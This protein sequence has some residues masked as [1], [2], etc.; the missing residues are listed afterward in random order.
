MARGN[1][2]VQR[3]EVR[4]T[5]TVVFCD[6]ADS[7]G[8]GERM[9]PESLRHLMRR[10]Y[11][12]MRRVVEV[13]GG[14]CP[15]F[16]GDAVMAVFGA[17]ALHEDDA[18]RAVR[19]AVGMASALETLNPEL[20]SRWGVRLE[21]KTGVNTGQV[22][23]GALSEGRSFVLGDPVNVAARLQGAAAAG[24]I[25]IGEE[26]HRLVRAFVRTEPVEPL[27]LKGKAQ[28]VRAYTVVGFVESPSGVR[29]GVETPLVGRDRELELLEEAFER[30]RSQRRG[31]LVTVIGPAG[32]GKSRLVRDFVGRLD[33]RATT[34]R[35]RC[36][37]YGEGITFWPIAEIV[38]EAAA[39]DDEDDVA[40]ATGKIAAL[41]AGEPEAGEVAERIAGAIG[42]FE[43]ATDR[44]G[45][46]WATG[47]LL[48]ALARER[49]L[50]LVLDDLHWGEPTLLDLVEQLART[51]HPAGALIAA[52]ARPELVERRPDWGKTVDGA[53]DLVLPELDE[54][55]TLVLAQEVL[56]GADFD[57][58][59]IERAIAT[60]GGN[61]LFLLE[62]LRM[63][64]E[65]GL[66]EMKDGKWRA[67]GAAGV[68]L[69]VPPTIQALI[70]ARLDR[71]DP[72]E[73]A[74][75]QRASVMGQEFWLQAV[76]ELSPDT[77][78]DA[79][80]RHVRALV[81]KGLLQ[82]RGTS[83]AGQDTYRFAH[84]LLHDVAYDEL[85]KEDRA[86]LHE[87]LAAWVERKAGERVTE[88]EEI[89]GYHLEQAFR[90]RCELGTP[91][92]ETARLA[93]AASG[94]LAAA[95][96]RAL[97][98]GDMPAA[99][100]L[101]ER[102]TSLLDDDDPQ[103]IDLLPKLSIALAETG[104]LDHADALLGE[105]I[106]TERRGRSFL[107]YRDGRGKRRILGLDGRDRVTIGRR[108]AS[109]VPLEWDAEVS[110]TH[111]VLERKPEG[112]TLVDEGTSRNGSF[113]NARPVTKRLLLKD[114]DMMRFG[115]TAVL[116]QAPLAPP[117][118]ANR[119]RTRD[120]TAPAAEIPSTVKDADTHVSVLAALCRPL[121]RGGAER[122]PADE[123]IAAELGIDVERVG[124]SM[125]ALHHAFGTDRLPEESKRAQLAERALRSGFG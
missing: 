56:G 96:R 51:T 98:R 7:T 123:E 63:L 75:L 107:A 106:D 39:I 92:E 77:D 10:F 33:E 27:A 43:S 87:G 76:V 48:G 65:G 11:E 73:A 120:T 29:T 1:P 91:D 49:P 105:W 8:L 41:L 24:Q 84:M 28:P 58:A 112:W 31:E 3:R 103:R 15:E 125:E 60:S 88:Y 64:I 82:A 32:I 4:R 13:H 55:D 35:G 57:D 93:R 42:L 124:V 12:E 119:W 67:S 34:L 14:S 69:R 94:R 16:F 6:V 101:L 90:Y 23:P 110:R 71:L 115:S 118:A 117:R 46:F 70:A 72:G 44:E 38:K 79:M 80:D 113:V 89:L 99:A 5:V 109:D 122:P 83:F 61:P 62:L 97:A 21:I 20:E 121:A 2:P 95:G 17:P 40:T 78:A 86:E 22:V 30:A 52:T 111:A 108:S 25:L 54:S 53:R 45:I 116:Y 36:L 37:P 74:L 19:A 9:D 104:R 100:T 114:G 85:L 47:R 59:A 68:E 66:L 50:V 102:A 18:L 81:R 26:T